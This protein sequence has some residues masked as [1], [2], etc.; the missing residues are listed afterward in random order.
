VSIK[1]VEIRAL[2]LKDEIRFAHSE[3]LHQSCLSVCPSCIVYIQ[4]YSLGV[5][6]DVASIIFWR[7]V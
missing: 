2:F 4:T 7:E 1:C 3:E 5:S 6:T